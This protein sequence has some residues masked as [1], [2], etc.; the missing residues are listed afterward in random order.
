MKRPCKYILLLC[1][2]ALTL[3]TSCVGEE[4]EEDAWYRP[5][6]EFVSS[7]QSL[8]QSD[9]D[10]MMTLVRDIP[11]GGDS[12]L[13][14]QWKNLVIAK[15]HFLKGEDPQCLSIVDSVDAFCHKHPWRNET[16]RLHYYA[17]NLKGILLQ[18]AGEREKALEC[19]TRS[20]RELM[21]LK[22]RND[23]VDL[24]INAADV[25]R[26]LGRLA[27]ASSWY[28]RANFL[29]DSLGLHETQNSILSGLGQVYNDLQNYRLAHF[30]FRKAEQQYPPQNPKDTQ[31]FYN[32]WGNVYSSQHKPQEALA[33]FLKAKEATDRIGHPMMKA[34]VDANLGQTYLE[35]NQTDSASK[36][37]ALA[38]A[39]FMRE[40]NMDSDA[41][42][43]LDGL[44][45][46]LALR[47]DS[48][49]KAARILQKPYNLSHMP[50]NYLYLYH[51]G[52]AGLYERRG[53]FDKALEYHKLMQQ[54]DDSLRNAT[55]LSNVQENELRFMQDTAIV[56]RDMTL[57]ATREQARLSK[58]ISGMAIV[59]LT[60][61]VLALVFF[62]RYKMLRH[63]HQHHEEMRRMMSLKMENVRN[64][65]SPHFV[66][67]V[68]NV[69]I[70]NLPKEVSVQ[71]LRL[72][73]QVL[74][75]NLLTCNKIAVTLEEELQMVKSYAALRHE[76]NPFLPLPHFDMAEGVD[77][78]LM[79]PSMIVQIPV[80][81]AL[82]HA[83]TE[84]EGRGELPRLD[85][86]IWVE[87]GMLR[88]DV[89]D[90]GCGSTGGRTQRSQ[91][92]S[93]VSTGT[94]LRILH[95]TIEMLNAGNERQMYF[96]M[97]GNEGHGTCVSIGVPCEYDYNVV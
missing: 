8:M 14:A 11:C 7:H 81:N 66:F 67:N 34:V 79:L 82:K 16:H 17:Q 1:V 62:Y 35:L 75:A 52:M 64:R 32:S 59:L 68:L 18:L 71:P 73:I 19:Y 25:S 55:M 21:Q 4:G 60:V 74:R 48:L 43:Y 23:A 53:M 12:V 63:A 72:L 90:N 30:Y 57:Q 39:V 95:S 29:A 70:S 54:Y 92:H 15:C 56:R 94:G 51:R 58:V 77:T 37:L 84:M 96:R 41:Q 36:Y 50:P 97:L 20:Y 65:F 42:F 22:S 89:V 13:A 85:V 28:R 2:G 38:A 27:D 31:F 86:K 5:V 88:I 93:A 33:C 9:P 44:N 91:A 26:Q 83:F 40:P 76:T 78:S 49:A 6:D 3:L 24:C 10:S 46:S 61:L 80:E 69:F 47:Q 87:D 45:V